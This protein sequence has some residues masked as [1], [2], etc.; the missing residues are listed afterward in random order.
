MTR[1]ATP[2]LLLETHGVRI[3]VPPGFDPATLASVLDMLD[4]RSPPEGMR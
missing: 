4:R 1:T 2:S 3:G